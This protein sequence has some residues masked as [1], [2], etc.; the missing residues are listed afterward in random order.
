MTEQ[1]KRNVRI[2]HKNS[3]TFMNRLLWVCIYFYHDYITERERESKCWNYMMLESSG[4]ILKIGCVIKHLVLCGHSYIWNVF[5][6]GD[7]CAY[8]INAILNRLKCIKCVS[9][10]CCDLCNVF[11]VLMSD[12]IKHFNLDSIFMKRPDAKF[13]CSWERAREPKLKRRREKM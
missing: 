13:I 12:F 10:A 1:P 6:F 5:I 4:D 9:A 11:N 3:I 8:Y 2:G 7:W